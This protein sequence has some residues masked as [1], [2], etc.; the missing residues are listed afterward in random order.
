MNSDF[1][2]CHILAVAGI[3]RVSILIQGGSMMIKNALKEDLAAAARLFWDKGLSTGFDAGDVSLRDP[4][5]NL[6]YICPRPGSI[7]KEIPNWGIMRAEYVVVMDLDGKIIDYA[8]I[9]ATVEA[10]MHLEI[11]K[12]RSD[13]NA[14]V[15]SHAVYSCA[16]AAAGE[17]VPLVL[18]ESWHVGK[19]II[20]APYGKV[21]SQDLADNICKVLGQENYVALLRRHGAAVCGSSMEEAFRISDFLEKLC[22]VVI[23]SKIIKS[24]A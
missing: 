21:G 6:V 9:D 19:E 1:Y 13:I 23:L 16:F 14:I 8:G 2:G 22:K 15:H 5:T 18:D 24:E 3:I 20:C 17:N 4:E 12:H 11:Y 10:P 7:L